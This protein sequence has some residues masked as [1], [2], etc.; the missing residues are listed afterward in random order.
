MRQEALKAG[1]AERMQMWAGQSAKL[2]RNERAG[3]ITQQLWEE[4][5]RLLA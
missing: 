4:A 5:S 3:T 2:A 1:D